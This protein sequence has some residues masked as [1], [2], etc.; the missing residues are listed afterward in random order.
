MIRPIILGIV[1]GACEFLPVSSS[2]HLA[3]LQVEMGYYDNMLIYDIYL[4]FATV[5]A[6]LLY[7]KPQVKQVIADWFCGFRGER[8]RGWNYGWAIIFTTIITGIIGILLKSTAERFLQDIRSVALGE[9]ITGIILL[10]M[11]IIYRPRIYNIFTLSVIV[12]I[13]QGISVLPGISRSGMSIF[14]CVLMGMGITEAFRYSFLISIPSILG[15]VIL[16]HIKAAS[17]MISYVFLPDG[18]L[19]GCFVA[20]LLGLLSLKLMY[21]MVN[22]KNWSYFGIYCIIL[23][24]FLMLM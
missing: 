4:H 1:Q 16:E 12:G 13:A 3:V 2:G 18:G 24:I 7:F 21:R 22:I 15:A 11:P 6:T 17:G 23:G 14:A 5:L 20:L 8:K 19:I 10:L 9:I